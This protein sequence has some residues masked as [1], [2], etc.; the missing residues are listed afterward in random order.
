MCIDIRW[1][2]SVRNV[3]NV[4]HVNSSDAC[5]GGLHSLAIPHSN[6]ILSWG[7]NQNGVLGLGHHGDMNVSTPTLVPDVYASQVR[8]QAFASVHT[9]QVKLSVNWVG[10]AAHDATVE[11][12]CGAM[13]HQSPGITTTSSLPFTGLCRCKHTVTKCAHA[14]RDAASIIS[15][16]PIQSLFWRYLDNGHAIH[17]RMTLV[18]RL[19]YLPLLT[20]RLKCFCMPVRVI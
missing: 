5:A 8:T 17:L 15:T 19:L 16:V 7:A 1:P 10:C 3:R 2:V 13:I 6:H 12:L 4:G 14:T 20:F 11:V 9:H 18:I